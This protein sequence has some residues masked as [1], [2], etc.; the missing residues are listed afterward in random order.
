[1]ERLRPAVLA[2][3]MALVLGGVLGGG[4]VAAVAIRDG[5]IGLQ[6]LSPKVQQLLLDKPRPAGPKRIVRLIP[7]PEGPA[8]PR[9]ERG[10]E[11]PQ[12]APGDDASESPEEPGPPELATYPAPQCEVVQGDCA[13]Y[14][15]DF[16]RAHA[17]FEEY[18]I[19]LGVYPEPPICMRAVQEGEGGA[20]PQVISFLYPNGELGEVAWSLSA[21][22]KGWRIGT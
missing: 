7:G 2:I 1:M 10:P 16:W 15:V 3:I 11:G 14:S 17:I 4:A 22:A 12:G 13:M 9:G 20:C 6:K 21:D 18:E 19:D 5:S 8:G